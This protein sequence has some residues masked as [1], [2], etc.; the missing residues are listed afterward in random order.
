MNAPWK[1]IVW[2]AGLTAIILAG[3]SGCATPKLQSPGPE[4]MHPVE[5]MR[6]QELLMQAKKPKAPGPPPFS[7]QMAP[8]DQK[9]YTAPKLYSLDFDKAPLGEVI[10]ALTKESEYNLSIESEVDLARPITVRLKN[11]TLEEA[12][13]MIVVN[14]SGYA[15]MIDKGTLQIKRFVERIYHLD[16]LDL[17]SQ[18]DIDV[19]GDMLASGVEDSG[20]SGKYQI[21][22]KS[23][24]GGTDLW[25]SVEKALEEMK[26]ADGLLRINRNAGIIYMADTPRKTASMV[27]FLD[28]LS[29]ALHR[30]VFIEARIMEVTLDD[31]KQYGIDWTKLNVEFVPRYRRLPDVFELA[32]NGGSNVSKGTQNVFQAVMD[33]L[34]TQGDVRILSNPH[35]SVMNRQSALMTVGFQFPYTDIDGVDRDSETGVVTIGTSIKRAVLGLQLG[36]TPQISPEGIITFHIVPTL[37][38]IEREVDVEIPLTG[39]SVQAISNPVIDLQELSTTVRV[40][41]GNSFVLAGL[42]S[43]I[44]NIKHEGLPLLGDLPF[45]GPLFKHIETS[46]QNSEL[47]I[48]VT[49]YI[50]EGV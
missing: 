38:R 6:P 20:V 8:L 35:L 28:S 3:P 46:E 36:L 27:R 31:D 43:K 12:L 32:I 50:L 44:R 13:E 24:E 21:K 2:F 23:P 10:S 19:G 42:I 25:V 11:V 7:E 9:V 40:R 26:S 47:V 22:A 37:T 1:I 5:Q 45:F 34:K 33:L 14:G 29:E 49:P 15:W 48:L 17:V 41:E 39:S 4:K 18:T 16:Y 30:Q